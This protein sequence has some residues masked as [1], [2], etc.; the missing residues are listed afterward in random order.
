MSV[1]SALA[2]DRMR[3]LG[4]TPDSNFEVSGRRICGLAQAGA[5][6]RLAGD[7]AVADIQAVT[8]MNVVLQNLPPTLVGKLQ[9][10]GSG[11]RPW[12]WSGTD[13]LF[14]RTTF[15]CRSAAMRLGLQVALFRKFRFLERKSKMDKG[16]G[17]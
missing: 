1:H 3:R 15:G 2:I 17:G 10:D 8:Q 4:A 14:G 16:Y 5:R 7:L 9:F 11:F 6:D 12:C 13:G